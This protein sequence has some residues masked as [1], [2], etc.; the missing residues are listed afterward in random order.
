MTSNNLIKETME[1]FEK[2]KNKA[3]VVTPSIPILYFGDLKQYGKS[4]IKIITAGKN[5]SYN[6]FQLNKNEP[7]NLKRFSTYNGTNLTEC[8]NQYFEKQPFK[9]W[10]ESFEPIL[11]GLNASFYNQSL[12]PN[13]ALH[14]DI[15]SPL[16]TFPTWSKLEEKH[17][18][19][20][21]EEGFILWQKLIKELDPDIILI[22]VPK[23][24]FEIVHKTLSLTPKG[25]LISFTKKKNN[26][27]RKQP[28][29]VYFYETI[30]N[31]KATK[32]VY[33]RAAQKPFDTISKEQKLKIGGKI[34]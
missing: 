27:L 13:R 8:L 31:N 20:L 14:T 3:Y 12:Y 33:G 1:Y 16:A 30:L 2:H 23:K 24:L 17:R 10:F 4:K 11:N 9:K 28:Y 15:C 19:D 18:E 21:F 34:V 32:I 29:N 5:P 26:E 6:E 7:F 22:S 25:I